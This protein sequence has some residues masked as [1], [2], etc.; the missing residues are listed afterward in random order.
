VYRPVT[1]SEISD[2]LVHIRDLYR[3]IKPADEQENR[4]YERR[5][6]GIKDLLSNL[7]RTKEHPT[8]TAVDEVA[9]MA[10]LTTEGAHRLFGYNLAKIREYDLRLNGGRT[11]IVESYP[12]E[13]D[14]LIDLPLEFASEEIFGFGGMLR[15][16][17]TKWQ[18]DIPMRVLEEA[19]WLRPGIFFVHI[20]TED[21]LGSSLPPGSL[22]LV[23]PIAEDEEFHPNPRAIYLLQF[24]NGYCC[25]RCVVSRGKLQLL[26]SERTYLGPQNFDYPGAVRIVGRAR[27]F[28]LKLPLPEY[29]SRYFL[30]LGGNCADLILP[31]EQMTRNVLFATEHM[32]FKRTKKEEQ[33][34]RDAFREVF[35]SSPSQRTERR[36][37][38][39]TPSEPHVD[40][41]IYFTVE[42]FARY[43]DALRTGGS[44]IT[45]T[46]RFSLETLLN[47]R[48]WAD[49]LVTTPEVRLP[50]PV[51]AWEVYRTELVEWTPLLSQKFPELRL[52]S[53]RALRLANEYA[54]QGL[55]P[56]IAPGSWMFLEKAPAI[57]NVQ[58]EQRKSGWSRPIYVLRRGVETICGYLERDGSGYALLSSA[59]G[60]G[61]KTTL[62]RDELK[63]LWR[64]GCVL[65]PV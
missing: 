54:I 28:A 15:D 22:A 35:G 44:L 1:R 14:R 40:S 33:L 20:G 13:R 65:I 32:R 8:L 31:T 24:G 27:M 11:H 6:V 42:N 41:L 2:A 36:Y 3:Q 64:A 17:V 61:S 43:T 52:W 50:Q 25:S 49:V 55:D 46:G 39:F 18:T 53:D 12:F 51:K 48:H 21:S 4:A 19:G 23:E 5:E 29:P 45:D 57:P 60:Y 58:S 59:Y 7:P 16:M 62:V 56:A 34:V 63:D 30:P 10:R 9:D 38:A 26:T 47:A 37:R